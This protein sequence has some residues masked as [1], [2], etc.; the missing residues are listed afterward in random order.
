VRAFT[1]GAP[2][3]ELASLVMLASDRP[4]ELDPAADPAHRSPTLFLTHPATLETSGSRVLTDDYNPIH[5]HRLGATRVW[6]QAM[7]ENIGEDWAYW[8]DF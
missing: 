8:A 5:T 7:I 2:P 1:D 6:R 3:A 4:I